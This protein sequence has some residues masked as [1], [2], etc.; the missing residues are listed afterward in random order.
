M[1]IKKNRSIIGSYS[2]FK[3]IHGQKNIY[4]VHYVHTEMEV[5]TEYM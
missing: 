1:E 5:L 2:I 4:D 3:Y